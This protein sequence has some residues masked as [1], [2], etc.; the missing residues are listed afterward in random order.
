MKKACA[1]KV[2]L[3]LEWNDA[4]GACGRIATSLVDNQNTLPVD[5]CESLNKKLDIVRYLSDK[6]KKDLDSHL[7]T[8]RCATACYQQI[9]DVL[10]DVAGTHKLL[11]E[12]FDTLPDPKYAERDEASAQSERLVADECARVATSIRGR[13]KHSNQRLKP[14]R[15]FLSGVRIWFRLS[16][17][18]RL[19]RNFTDR[20]RCH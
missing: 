14:V 10:D 8:H 5:Q 12:L 16:F 13:L 1:A 9:A 7:L 15:S 11:A 19:I 17:V 4:T 20:V 2:R 3:E 18:P 6:L